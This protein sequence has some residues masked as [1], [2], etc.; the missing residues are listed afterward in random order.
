[1]LARLRAFLENR[2]VLSLL[3]QGSRAGFN[4]L[5]FI[6][7]AR[8][9]TQEDLG[10]WILYLTTKSFLDLCRSGI[11]K[12]AL[13]R[14]AAG[15]D[16]EEQQAY[17]GAGWVL[18]VFMTAVEVGLVLAWGAFVP[19]PD[20][21]HAFVNW[22]PLLAW[23]SLPHRIGNWI[24][25]ATNHFERQVAGHLLNSGGFALLVLAALFDSST[26]TL[27]TF[28][29]AHVVFASLASFVFL[30][31]GWTHVLAIYRSHV[32]A[33]RRLFAFGK[34]SVGTMIGSD[35]LSSSDTYILGFMMGPSGVALYSV[36]Q[37]AVQ[38]VEVPL[39]ALAATAYPTFSDLSQNEDR[40]AL[41]TYV[42][43]WTALTT[44]A[45][46]PML[47]ALFVFAEPV[48]ELLGGKKYSAAAPIL[49]WFTLY[50]LFRPLGRALGMLLDSLN[51]PHLSFSKVL[52]QLAVNVV[53]DIAVL[54]YWNSVPAV[55]AVTTLTL[56]TGVVVGLR[57][58]RPAAP[59]H[60]SRLPSAGRDALSE[61]WTQWRHPSQEQP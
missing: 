14:F 41:Q 52:I 36:G 11:V 7:L 55:A 57:F 42:H 43:R 53:G 32:E 54:Y 45:F 50:L 21:F 31:T 48:V 59:V 58:V 27:N 49:R 28:V 23:A 10:A 46:L 61:Y 44:L 17:F 16:G 19:I 25:E 22:Y 18:A 40:A 3:S 20:G 12:P 24:A 6:L 1:M 47:A 56:I 37:K 13:V 29:G 9:L 39:Q 30:G 5:A 26:W 8:L 15:A 35:L 51:W 60:L 2:H 38:L 34:Y 33:F 4:M